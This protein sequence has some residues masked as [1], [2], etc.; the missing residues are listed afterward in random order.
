M[1]GKSFEEVKEIKKRFSSE[2]FGKSGLNGCG[3]GFDD[4]GNY[5]IKAYFETDAEMKGSGVPDE[6]EEVKVVK[7]V[8][9][10]VIAF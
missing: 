6:Y 2:Y 3:I 10:R 7:E 5:C 9:G 8:I 1:K 4:Q